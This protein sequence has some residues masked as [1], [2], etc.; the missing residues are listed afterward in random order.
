MVLLCKDLNNETIADI[1]MGFFGLFFLVLK[2]CV[3]FSLLKKKQTKFC[4]LI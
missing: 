4:N 2:F 1:L 3:L